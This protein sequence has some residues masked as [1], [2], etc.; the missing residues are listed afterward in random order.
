[1]QEG[2]L[3]IVSSF[4]EK[5]V[6]S[7]CREERDTKDLYRCNNFKEYVYCKCVALLDNIC[8]SNT[9]RSNLPCTR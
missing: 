3:S 1:M 9:Q 6:P 7:D 8:I 2:Y 4:P 5:F